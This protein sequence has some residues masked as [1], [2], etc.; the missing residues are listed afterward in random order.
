MVS[1]SS[2]WAEPSAAPVRGGKR[3][4]HECVKGA[5]HDVWPR[6]N[7]SKPHP[8]AIVLVR[9]AVLCAALAAALAA[10]HHAAAASGVKYG[11]TDD[12]WLSSGPG[13]LESRLATLDVLGVRIVRFTLN[14]NQ[15]A[16]AKPSAATDPADPAYDWDAPGQVIDGLRA[17]GIEVILQLVGTPAWANGGKPG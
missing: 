2:P 12:A 6:R 5:P 8:M 15:V 17:H 7:R 4:C 9:I 16:R 11:L 14:W 3:V 1:P 10:P 13:T